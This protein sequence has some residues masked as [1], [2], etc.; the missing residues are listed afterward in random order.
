MSSTVASGRRR[1]LNRHG[2]V[3]TARFNPPTIDPTGPCAS[4]VPSIPSLLAT[5]VCTATPSLLGRHRLH[6]HPLSARAL[7]QRERRRR[8]KPTGLNRWRRPGTTP[9]ACFKDRSATIAGSGTCA[10][11]T[12]PFL[13]L[14]PFGSVRLRAPIWHSAS[15]D[16]ADA[17]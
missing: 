12:V 16:A 17:L 11:I 7:R 3:N 14:F 1:Q 13:L 10:S 4:S 5:T 2:L 15:H 6:L 9:W 8:R